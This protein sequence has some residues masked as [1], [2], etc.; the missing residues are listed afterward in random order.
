MENFSQTSFIDNNNVSD[1]EMIE[2]SAFNHPIMMP[3]IMAQ[4]VTLPDFHIKSSDMSPSS[5]KIHPYTLFDDN[6]HEN[7]EFNV[8]NTQAMNDKQQDDVNNSTWILYKIDDGEDQDNQLTYHHQ[9]AQELKDLDWDDLPNFIRYLDYNQLKEDDCHKANSENRTLLSIRRKMVA[10]NMILR[11]P[12]KG[13]PFY[14]SSKNDFQEKEVAY[15]TQTSTWVLL[16]KLNGV[17]QNASQ[18]CLAKIIEEIETKLSHLLDSKYINE[19][20]HCQMNIN[21]SLVRMHYLYFVPET[22]KEEIPVRPIMVCN[23]GPTMNIVRYITPLLWSIFDRATNCR[24]FQNG[25]IDVIHA[26]EKYAQMGHLKPDETIDG[27]TIDIILQLVHLVLQ[28]QFCVYNNGL[29][30]QI[31]GGASG[32]PLTMLLTY[33]NLFYGQHS[34]LMKT[35]EE[36]NEFFG[37]YREQAILTWH[38]SEDAFR[39]LIKKSIHV[40]HTEHLMTMSIGSTVHFHDIEI[41]HNNNDVLE[42]KVYY[43]PNIDTLPNVSDEPMENKSKQLYAVLYRAVRCCSNVMKFHHERHHKQLADYKKR[44]I[45]WWKKY[46]GNEPQTKHIQIKWVE[47]TSKNLTNCDILVNKRPPIHLLTLS[48]NEKE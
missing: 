32:L 29:Y 24:R 43:D 6:T 15:I 7:G 10:N 18:L 19:L 4:D 1:D 30:Q 37:R 47:S 27:L 38:G 13:T 21:R 17:H 23:D 33:V 20:H 12:Y 48:K 40:E 16:H 14:I 36:K 45:E 3:P 26:M 35:I 25:S 44:I 41:S 8:H 39:T 31:H 28:N 42:S 34:E 22:H 46:Y 11:L 2:K 5:M 9:E